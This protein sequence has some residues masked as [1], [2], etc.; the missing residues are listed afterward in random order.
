MKRF[1]LAAAFLA[2]ACGAS[3]DAKQ[4]DAPAAPQSLIDQ[5]LAMS[6][7]QQPVFAWQLLTQYQAAHPEAVPPCA[8]VRQSESRGTIPENIDPES[9]YGPYAGAWVF[10]VQCGPQLTDTRFDPKEHWIVVMSP[11]A[12][13]PVVHNCADASGRDICPREVPTVTAAEPAT[14]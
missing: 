8:S 7:E 3:D 11:G 5:A 12:M 13:E 1:I 6:P 2:A 9:V 14:P 10:S 4:S